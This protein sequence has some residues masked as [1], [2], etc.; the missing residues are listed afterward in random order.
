MKKAKGSIHS[1]TESGKVFR[2]RENATFLN[3]VSVPRKSAGLKTSDPVDHKKSEI[4]ESQKKES[5]KEM[6]KASQKKEPSKEMKKAK[7]S[8]HSVTESGT[9]S[10]V[11]VKVR[12]FFSLLS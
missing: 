1:V 3:F 4:Q 12:L 6:K 8:S 5:S 11:F 10:L 2:V 7:G 9:S